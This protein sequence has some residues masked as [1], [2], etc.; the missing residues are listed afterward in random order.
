[1]KVLF[2]VIEHNRAVVAERFHRRI[3]DGDDLHERQS[4]CE[5]GELLRVAVVAKP[6]GLDVAGGGEN[7]VGREHLAAV[8]F[9]GADAPVLDVQSLH[10]APHADGAADL[11]HLPAQDVDDASNPFAGPGQALA[12]DAFEHH[13]ELA[14][15]HVPLSRVAVDHQ[16]AKEHV[17]Q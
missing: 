16:G 14:E 1:M 6:Q 12:E 4:P 2:G 7:G 8:E 13:D 17:D 11:P 5:R 15:F 9:H 10:P 3:Q